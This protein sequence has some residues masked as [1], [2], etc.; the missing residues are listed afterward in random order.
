MEGLFALYTV[1]NNHTFGKSLAMLEEEE[2]VIAEN[3]QGTRNTSYWLTKRLALEN[4]SG[5][6]EYP[7]AATGTFSSEGTSTFLARLQPSWYL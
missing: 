1:K 4:G 5:T 3:A 6:S 2:T 7:T